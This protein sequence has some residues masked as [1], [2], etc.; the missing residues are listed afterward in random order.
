MGSYSAGNTFLDFFAR[1][2][3]SLGLPVI[4]VGLGNISEVGYLHE[5]PEI[6][7]LMAR[8]AVR[9]I[10]EDEMLQILD[11]ALTESSKNSPASNMQETYDWGSMS[12]ILAG[13]EFIDLARQR[14]QGF[15]ANS[16]VLDDPR[17]SHFTAA[18]ARL[19]QNQDINGSSHQTGNL[20]KELASALK[21][22]KPASILEAVQEIVASKI[23]NLILLPREQLDAETH[24]SKFG[25]DSMIAAEFRGYVFRMLDVDVPFMM[26]LEKDTNVKVL[27]Q[28]IAKELEQKN[29]PEGK[30]D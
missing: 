28:L 12:H 20:P 19:V 13:V 7:A 29:K 27:A 23:A 5:H 21:G 6:E 18:F 15:E 11:I 3:Q 10:N 4:S 16:H 2:R 9:T 25:L 30:A 8:R 24:F 14:S 17:A 26:L 22:G 1:Y